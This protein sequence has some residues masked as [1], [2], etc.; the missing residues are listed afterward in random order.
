MTVFPDHPF[1]DFSLDLYGKPGVAVACLRLQD[2]LGLDVN[3]LM[4]GCWVA[5]SGGG[6]LGDVDWRRIIDATAGWRVAVVEQLR[7]ARRRMKDADF[8]GMPGGLADSLRARIKTL[9]LDAEHA[10]QLALAGLL[11][12]HPDAGRSAAARRS[13]A[14]ANMTGY[15]AS[16]GVRPDDAGRRDIEAIAAAC[17]EIIGSS[18]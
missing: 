12:R 18:A 9:E 8:P 13:D 4:A 7:T 1:W 5:A 11:T 16:A 15:A 6:R 14:I 17:A 10:Q 2:R 3:L